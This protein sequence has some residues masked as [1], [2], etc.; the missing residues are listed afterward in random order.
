MEEEHLKYLMNNFKELSSFDHP[1]IISYKA[2]YVDM[3]KH[4]GWLVMDLIE[5][6]SLDKLPFT[7][8]EEL[9]KIMSQVFSAIRYLHENEFV[10]RDIKP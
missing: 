9:K 1:N 2:L 4:E 10:H 7:E 8:E 6:V 3:N 5:G